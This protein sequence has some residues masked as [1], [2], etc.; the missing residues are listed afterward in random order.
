[1]I[2]V[3]IVDDHKSVLDAFSNVIHEQSE[4]IFVG[5]STSTMAALS[6]IE[7][8][9]PDVILSDV[10]VEENM[11][12]IMFCEQVKHTYPHIR[13][14]LMSGFDEIS[15]I[16]GA[17]QAKADAFVSKSRP[18]NE[19]IQMIHKTIEGKGSFP[20]P[21]TIP[22]ANGESPFTERE[23]EV[24]RLLCQS[25]SRQEIADELNIAMGTVKRHLENMLLKSGCKNSMELVVYV[26]G[27]GWISTK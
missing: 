23:L 20:T 6:M 19:F 14:I 13:V 11:S 12:G 22:T 10:C 24:L 18:M 1:M 15:Y 9:K 3:M 5:S 27:N 2:K 21:V 25:Y 16:P 17:I 7:E 4:L 8:L 26:I